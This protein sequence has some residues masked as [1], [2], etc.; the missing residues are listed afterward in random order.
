MELKD[1]VRILRKQW[2]LIAGVTV[3]MVALAAT[4]TALRTPQYTATSQL[5]VSTSTASNSASDL[6][7]GN[8]FTSER[9]K[10]YAQTVKTSIV[11]E[12]VITSLGLPDTVG[13]LA[14]RITANAPLNTV[15]LEISV[16]DPNPQQAAAI[17][18]AIGDTLPKVIG[19]VEKAN[20]DGT[21]PVKISTLQA[22]VVPSSPSS[23]NTKLNWALGLL[24][25]LA[26][27]VGAAVLRSTLDNKVRTRDDL[28][29]LTNAPVI[30]GLP[31]DNAFNTTPLVM[32]AEPTGTT[33]EAF[34]S[35]RT[36]LQFVTVD[37]PHSIVVTSATPAE[38]KTTTTVN[39]AVSLSQSGL[40]VL[41]VDADLRRPRIAAILGLEGAVGLT[42]VL[43]GS[44]SV[45]DVIQTW[46]EDDELAVLPAGQV[47]PNPS[48][49]LGSHS[50]RDLIKQLEND[51]DVVLFDS[52][53]LLPVADTAVLSRIVG[54]T[55]LVVAAGQ[56]AKNEVIGALKTLHAVDATVLG[57]ILT[58]L[59]IKGPDAYSYNQYGYSSGY[60]SNEE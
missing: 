6:N 14:S 4:Y 26:L 53:P 35:M 27:G 54:G 48:E 42:D 41:C 32:V 30:G 23:P 36:N 28:E 43:A 47:P 20:A 16:T 7:A 8:T 40:R 19:E 12:P 55:A 58:K 37:R 56:S 51:Y 50:M 25:G 38:G 33:A 29:A 17:V 13:E 57:S 9:V 2:L 60:L 15:L 1:Y 44:Y 31:W 10:S 5:F 34:R 24:V 39:L 22:A 59:P 11:L 49:L 52:A 46:G 18:N 3:V 21:S 45:D